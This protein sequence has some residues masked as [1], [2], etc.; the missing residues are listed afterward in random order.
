[1]AST[2]RAHPA[3]ILGVALEWRIPE[4]ATPDI[5]IDSFCALEASLPKPA[6]LAKEVFRAVERH[7]Y[8]ESFY[9]LYPKLDLFKPYALSW[10]PRTAIPLTFLAA[11]QAFPLLEML[12]EETSACR[13]RMLKAQDF[14]ETGEERTA[15]EE[16]KKLFDHYGSDKATDHDYHFIYGA[17]LARMKSVRSILEVGLGTNNTDV[18]SNMGA[19][20]KPGASLRAFRDFLP[21]AS[22]YGADI[23]RR[24]LFEEE[25]IRTFF[26]DQTNLG[27][28]VDVEA[29]GGFDVVIDD[30]LHSPSANLAVLL[31]GIRR[32]RT[33]GWIVIEDIP[34]K[35]LPV[36][37]VVGSILPTT[38]ATTII[39]AENGFVF[40]AQRT[41]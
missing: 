1:L 29:L 18:V 41:C 26:I 6:E 13:S 36:W 21:E 22:I 25:R 17:I 7:R 16:I 23:D 37:K 19:M 31:L 32:I 8:G 35:A 38:Y 27:S 28:F 14:C 3:S 39:Q 11:Q 5:P 34:A 10:L 33:E 2:G 4:I 15:A 20:G 12:V 40:A 30:G 24:V 9:N